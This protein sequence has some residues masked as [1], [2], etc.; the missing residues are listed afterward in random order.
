MLATGVRTDFD[1]AG[2][3]TDK[4]INSFVFSPDGTKVAFTTFSPGKLYVVDGKS[5]T[6]PYK[7]L[8]TT[9]LRGGVRWQTIPSNQRVYRFWSQLNK[10]HF[11]TASYD[12]ALHVMLEYPNDEW[13]YE[14]SSYTV[15]T[16]CD[17]STAVYR[18]W[19][20]RFRSHFYT[21]SAAERDHITASYDQSTWK[22][23]GEAFCASP[24]AQSGMVP[25]YRFWSE[26]YRGH[27]YTSSDDEKQYVIDTYDNATWKYEGIAYYVY[28]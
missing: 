8:N 17:G 11:Y 28:L 3:F 18:F 22:Y 27:F 19:S 4:Y 14:Q 15:P 26:T 5:S 24:S 9:D 25:V 10:H 7:Q 23:E 20:D 13:N 2:I 12:E 16:A 1:S 6:S 21:I